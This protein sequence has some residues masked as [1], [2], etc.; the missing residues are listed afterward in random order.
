MRCRRILTNVIPEVLSVRLDAAFV[1]SERLPSTGVLSFFRRG[2]AKTCVT[3]TPPSW[4]GNG[5]MSLPNGISRVLLTAVTMT[6]YLGFGIEV[7]WS[8]QKRLCRD[9]RPDRRAEDQGK[10][11]TALPSN[12]TSRRLVTPRRR[13]M[14]SYAMSVNGDAEPIHRAGDM[15][16]S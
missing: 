5:F 2:D 3:S 14:K 12:P 1:I 8:S 15:A 13:R 6:G 16:L 9:R 4:A 10:P 7:T 11:G